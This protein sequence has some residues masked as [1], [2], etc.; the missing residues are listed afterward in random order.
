MA[1]KLTELGGTCSDAGKLLLGHEKECRGV[2]E[3]IG[4][5]KFEIIKGSG[6][7]SFPRGCY[8]HTNKTVYWNP[9]E[10]GEKND[11]AQAI[12]STHGS[13]IVFSFQ[14]VCFSSED[15]TPFIR[16]PFL[17]NT[18]IQTTPILVFK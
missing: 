17:H 9:H 6:I 18:S 13:Y 12:C 5:D 14:F 4:A 7:A 11:L 2:A 15:F 1:F 16:S 10:T 3:L 8:L